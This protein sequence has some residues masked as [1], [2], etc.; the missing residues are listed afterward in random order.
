MK[1]SA[2]ARNALRKVLRNHAGLAR[3]GVSGVAINEMVKDELLDLAKKLG[4]DVKRVTA[5]IVEKPKEGLWSHLDDAELEM[6]RYSHEHPAFEG[7]LEFDLT[8]TL[9]GHT[10]TRKARV[11][12]SMTPEWKYYDLQKKRVVQGWEGSTMGLEVLAG[13]NIDD[14]EIVVAGKR[15]KRKNT[16][17]W[18]KI[19]LVEYGV[20]SDDVWTELENLI[21]KQ[22]HEEDTVRRS[23]FLSAAN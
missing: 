23:K 13:W 8:F 2:A 7:T 4:V 9:I 17:V 18:T 1:L 11:V 21:E 3:L 20:L 19:D 6:M 16:P 22:C 14:E 12:Y 10:V 5:G 15:S